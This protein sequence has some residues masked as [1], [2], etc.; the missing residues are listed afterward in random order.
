MLC[1]L[2]EELSKTAFWAQ[3]VETGSADAGESHLD[4]FEVHCANLL[5]HFLNVRNQLHN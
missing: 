2:H 3:T 4:L 5:F 1:F